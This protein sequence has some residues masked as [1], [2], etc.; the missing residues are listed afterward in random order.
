MSHDWDFQ[1]GFAEA[2][3][4]LQKNMQACSQGVGGAFGFES[5]GSDTYHTMER[6]LLRMMDDTGGSN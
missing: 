1:P 2:G 6:G 4:A 5:L 3:H